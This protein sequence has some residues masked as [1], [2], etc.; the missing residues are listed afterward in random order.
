MDFCWVQLIHPIL[1]GTSGHLNEIGRRHLFGWL[2]DGHW[3]EAIKLNF[4][5]YFLNIQPK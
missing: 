3:P 1:W 2:D 4:R 5:I